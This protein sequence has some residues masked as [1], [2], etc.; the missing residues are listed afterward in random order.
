MDN[1]LKSK[2]FDNKYCNN[3]IKNTKLIPLNQ[4]RKKIIIQKQNTKLS[5]AQ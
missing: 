2:T 3:E 4:Q 1:I 5:H